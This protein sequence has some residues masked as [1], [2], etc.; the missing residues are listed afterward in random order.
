MVPKKPTRE[1]ARPKGAVRQTR[2]T[3]G[4]F[5]QV[6]KQPLQQYI[7]RSQQGR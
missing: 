5:L 3:L 4:R 2:L 6:T 7:K 1:R